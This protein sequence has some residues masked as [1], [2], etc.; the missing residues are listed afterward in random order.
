MGKGHEVLLERYSSKDFEMGGGGRF[1]KSQFLWK[2][3][4]TR[5]IVIGYRCG[6]SCLLFWYVPRCWDAE[7]LLPLT[8]LCEVFFARSLLFL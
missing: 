4:G 8:G 1:G 6:C 7:G 2:L 5:V 3:V